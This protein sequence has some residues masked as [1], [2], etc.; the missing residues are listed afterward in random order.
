[1]IDMKEI[2]KRIKKQR[3]LMGLTQK[4]L[5]EL[6]DCNPHYISTIECGRSH[7]S[8]DTF[9]AIADHL[10]LSLDYMIHGNSPLENCPASLVNMIE[11]CSAD[12]LE[13]LEY[14]LQS[15]LFHRKSGTEKQE[16]GPQ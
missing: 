1:M 16:P 12:D 14:F 7:P 9:I 15:I 5:S 4:Q 6:V 13:H 3:K 2:G 8:A 11:M 10:H